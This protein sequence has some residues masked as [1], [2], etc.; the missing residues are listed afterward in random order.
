MVVLVVVAVGGETEQLGGHW[1]KGNLNIHCQ[2]LLKSGDSY[3][4]QSWGNRQAVVAD[5]EV[6][7]SWR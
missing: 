5:V 4:G 6:G 7:R 1:E 2:A 3:G